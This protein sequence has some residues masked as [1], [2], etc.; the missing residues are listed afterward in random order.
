VRSEVNNIVSPA[1]KVLMMAGQ[2]IPQA[3]AKVVWDTQSKTCAI[4]I[5]NLPPPPTDKQYQLWYV[6]PNAKISAAVFETDPTG[7]TV[8]RLQLPADIPWSSLAATAVT[9]EPRG[10]SRQPT[11]N[12]YLLGK[13]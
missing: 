13:I 8:L 10:G 12:L 3:S 11:S 2:E 6:K 4:Y 9:L 5:F 7:G 1:T